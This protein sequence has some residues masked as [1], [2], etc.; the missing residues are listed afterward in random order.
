MRARAAR[1]TM[2]FVPLI[3]THAPAY[4]VT[5]TYVVVIDAEPGTV[6]AGVNRLDLGT[7]PAPVRLPGGD[8]HERVHELTWRVDGCLSRIRAIWDVRVEGDG[9]GGTILSTTTRFVATDDVARERLL[10]AWGEIGRATR[11]LA[12]AA[13]DAVKRYAEE[14]E[15]PV[16]RSTPLP[17]PLAA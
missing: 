14:L 1:G 9:E 6:V 13:L 8:A 4:E 12:K 2:P 7:K 10:G 17:F 11:K 16:A 5:N 15:G 3:D